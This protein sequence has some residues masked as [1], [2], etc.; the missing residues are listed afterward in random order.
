MSYLITGLGNIGSEYKGTRHNIGFTVLD[1][2]ALSQKTT[3]STLRY[4]SMAQVRYAGKTIW[5]LKPSTYVNLSGKAVRYWMRE[6][7]I[8]IEKI[9][10]VLD[11]VALP[12]GNIRMRAKGSDGGHN[13]LKH[14]TY[15]LQTQDYARL[16]IG[17]GNDFP[18]G[19]RADYVLSSWK[20]EEEKNYP[21]CVIEPLTPFSYS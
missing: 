9:I 19:Y 13:G 5:L 2:W 18:K 1:A 11:D 14:I 21:F 17:V 3:F 4:G 20:K 6:E 15:M 16:R 7:R 8:P 12:F 10:I